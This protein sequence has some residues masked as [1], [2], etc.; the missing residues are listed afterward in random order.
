MNW[1]AIEHDQRDLCIHCQGTGIIIPNDVP[2]VYRQYDRAGNLLYVGMSRRLR[3]RIKQHR[4]SPWWS[5]ITKISYRRYQS[6]GQALDAEA[7]AIAVES[8]KYNVAGRQDV[9]FPSKTP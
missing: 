4:R 6:E 2:T 1:P 9:F 5:E 8:P 7:E 3:N